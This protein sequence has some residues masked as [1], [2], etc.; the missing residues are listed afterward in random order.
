MIDDDGSI[1][2]T[3]SPTS[4]RAS[5]VLYCDNEISSYKDD[6]P[7]HSES[8]SGSDITLPLDPI[9]EFPPP[10]A[11]SNLHIHGPSLFQCGEGCFSEKIK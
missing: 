1:S 6:L 3:P 10:T 2:S 7:P 11:S 9:T 8:Q 4:Y 5:A